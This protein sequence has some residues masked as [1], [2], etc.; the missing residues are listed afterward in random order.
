MSF[1]IIVPGRF[2]DASDRIP[3]A[4][5]Q[6]G[7]FTLEAVRSGRTIRSATFKNL[8][9]DLGLERYGSLGGNSLYTRC[10]VGTGTATP[11]FADTS[12]GNSVG[13]IPMAN[14]TATSSGAPDYYT[15]TV[16]TGTS[17]TGQFGS[18]NLTEIGMGSTG[19]ST[20]FSRALILDA[21]GNPTAFPIGSDEQLRVTYQ[22]RIYPPLT[23]AVFEVDVNGTREVTVRAMGVTS[24]A[25]WITTHITSS[26]VNPASF[27]SASEAGFYTGGVSAITASTPLG[28][29]VA[30][31]FAGTI[32]NNPYNA[33]SLK[34]SHR[35]SWGPTNGN[36]ASF[37]TNTVRLACGLFQAEYNPP[38][39][40]NAEQTMY[41]EYE[42]SWARR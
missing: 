39:S 22:L 34:R 11:T 33:G 7:W 2:I 9:T 31:S 18:V 15:T 8:I 35:R 1:E 40:K 10:H 13:M 19:A 14:P 17:T 26:S 27:G 42:S 20:L 6:E 12:L 5:R 38:L 4:M 29:Q 25:Y 23:D 30:N 21:I 32:V 16:F 36:S 3:L 41:L 24:A 28:T 37:R